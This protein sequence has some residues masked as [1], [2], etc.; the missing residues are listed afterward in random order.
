[1]C[2][3][4]RLHEGTRF[5]LQGLPQVTGEVVRQGTGSVVVR[6][7]VP[8]RIVEFTRIDGSVASIRHC[9]SGLT[10]WSR[11]TEVTRIS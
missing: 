1:M 11:M 8:E 7:D 2:H 4:R 10:T 5:R 3:L 6:L 9:K